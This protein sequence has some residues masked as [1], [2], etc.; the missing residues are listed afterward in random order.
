MLA[1]PDV[2]TPFQPEL[3]HA[4]VIAKENAD[5]FAG[6]T[7]ALLQNDALIQMRSNPLVHCF[8]PDS[9]PPG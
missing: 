3:G 6:G 8:V 1:E 4:S 9:T 2:C 5:G 7:A